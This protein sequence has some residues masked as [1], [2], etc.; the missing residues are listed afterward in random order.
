VLRARADLGGV[1]RFS[2]DP[3][4]IGVWASCR[5][6]SSQ[7]VTSFSDHFPGWEAGRP[8]EHSQL[9]HGDYH[10]YLCGYAER[11]GVLEHVRFGHEVVHVG[12]LDDRWRVIA[13]DRG[14]GDEST[15]V[16]DAVAVCSGIHRVPSIPELPGLDGFE[17]QI[18]HAAYYKGPASIQGRSAVFVGAG[19]SGGDI[20]GEASRHLDRA[21]LSLRRGVFVL[22]RLLNGFPNDYTGTRLLYSLPEFASRRSDPDALRLRRRIGRALLPLIALRA[23]I[24]ALQRMRRTIK[25]RNAT[26][27]LSLDP[28]IG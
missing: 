3:K 8:Y 18:L 25:Q 26:P 11:F 6:T 16:F 22:P 24:D 1:F 23:L 5:L 17:G 2:N 7:L 9:S 28:P 12:Q 4:T 20:I 21:H 14:C 10:A 27:A 19:E 13:T 15:E